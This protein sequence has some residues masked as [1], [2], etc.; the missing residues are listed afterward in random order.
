MPFAVTAEDQRWET[1]DDPVR[2]QLRWCL[3][4]DGTEPGP[5][6][7]TTGILQLD[8]AGW[9]GRHRHTAPEVYY[10]LEGR[11]VVALGGEEMTVGPGSLVRFQADAEHGV[12][13]AE[14][15]ARVLFLFPATGFDDVVYRFSAEVA[16]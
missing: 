9:L 1:W 12:R 2:G 13:A 14:G 10:V 16:A 15:P 8:A 3:L 7:V 5:E 6:S 4:V 11:A